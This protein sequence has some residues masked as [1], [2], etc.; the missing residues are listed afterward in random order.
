[1]GGTSKVKAG[2]LYETGEARYDAYFK[3]VHELQVASVGWGDD[4]KAA[5][6]PLV[7]VLRLPPEA[8]DVSVVQETHERVKAASRDVGPVK[9]EVSG[10]EV[11]LTAAEPAKVDEP[12]REFF[13]AVELCAHAEVTRAKALHEVPPKVDVLVKTGRE[14]EP[15]VRED[16]AKHGGRI[17]GEV[18]QEIAASYEVLGDVSHQARDGARQAEDFVA[19]LQRAVGNV[20]APAEEPA[21]P[22][23]KHGRG[24]TS[25][26]AAPPKPSAPPAPKPEPKPAPTSSSPTPPKPKPKPKPDTG[27]VFNP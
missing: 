7:D 5:C 16:F 26:K 15:H 20:A 14:L 24:H 17:P 22:E 18:Q 9:L 25:P 3:D 19:D 1:M 13:K 21:K 8:A 10:A 12:T 2:E 6:R 11:E 27:E 4:R 23:P